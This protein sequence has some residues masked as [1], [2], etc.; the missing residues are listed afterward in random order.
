MVWVEAHG[1]LF[2]EL[3]PGDSGAWVVHESTGEVYGHV[4]S[5]DSFGEACVLPIQG[6]LD[7]IRRHT[8]AK[9]VWLPSA[10]EID[11]LR[12]TREHHP[13]SGYATM[14]NS[15]ST[16]IYGLQTSA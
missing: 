13:D 16:A 8:K 4:V 2:L 10:I 1:V 6:T 12:Q 3:I 9:S 5:L 14:S 11:E 15:P 7:E